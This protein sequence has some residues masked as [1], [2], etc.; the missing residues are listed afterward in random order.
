MVPG[1]TLHAAIS[2]KSGLRSGKAR[3]LCSY[4]TSFCVQSHI[5][6]T[7]TNISVS[8]AHTWKEPLLQVEGYLPHSGGGCITSVVLL[9]VHAETQEVLEGEVALTATNRRQMLS[10][11]PTWEGKRCCF[12]VRCA[13]ECGQN[14]SGYELSTSGDCYIPAKWQFAPVRDIEALEKLKRRLMKGSNFL[15][16]TGSRY[17]STLGL[18]IDHMPFGPESVTIRQWLEGGGH[19]KSIAKSLGPSE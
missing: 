5:P 7:V 6:S 8:L 12:I 14:V 16:R 3:E 11:P 15:D 17:L 2:V 4:A 1:E 19:V 9:A 13:N 18:C 10:P